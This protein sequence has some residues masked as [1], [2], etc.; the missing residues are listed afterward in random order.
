MN[1]KETLKLALAAIWAHKLR[2]FLT[3]LGMIIAVAVFMLVLSVLAG[4]GAYIDEKIAGVGSNSFTVRRFDFKDFRNTDALAAAQRRNKELTLEE[5]EFVRNRADLVGNIGA[6]ARGNGAEVKRGSK[7]LEDVSVD[8]T[9]AIVATIQNF[10]IEKGRFFTESENQNARRVA[11]IGKDIENELFPGSDALGQEIFIRGI[12]YRV[13]GVQVPKGSVFGRP[14][15]NFITVPLKTYI[16]QFGA[17]TG[18]RGLYFVAS[19]KDPTK[20]DDAVEQVRALMRVKR[21]VP[22][23]ETDNFGISTPEAITQMRNQILG[24]TAIVALVVPTI[25]LVVGA[26]VIMNIMLVAVTERTKEIGIRL[27]LGARRKDILKQFLYEAG[28][29]SAIGGITGILVAYFAGFVV[30]HYVIETVIP[31]FAAVIAVGVSGIV[32][33]VAGI[34]PA[35]R[36]AR[37]DPIEAL[38]AD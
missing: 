26:I 2:S 7:K 25:A 1:L 21:K 30:S 10:D 22:F 12:P 15:D 37:L 27:A 5:V 3:L 34:Y 32:G 19:A 38:R 14:M 35:W 28:V 9:E 8:G 29:L 17:A 33:I 23:G 13:I 36:A 4:L 20:F 11:Y 24:P 18:P 31:W 6:L 16:S